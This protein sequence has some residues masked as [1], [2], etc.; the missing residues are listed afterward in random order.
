MAK[1]PRAAVRAFDEAWVSSSTTNPWARAY[2]AF[3]AATPYLFI[4]ALRTVAS[5]L[6]SGPNVTT[7][8][9]QV[10]EELNELADELRME[11]RKDDLGRETL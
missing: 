8:L 1:I 7:T 11:V 3:D 5:S 4:Q 2:A 6:G 9:W 10:A